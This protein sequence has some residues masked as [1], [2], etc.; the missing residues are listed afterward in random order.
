MSRGINRERQVKKRLE[1]DGWWVCRA[2][3]SLG[4]ADLVAGR[5]DKRPMLLEIKSDKAEY[6]PFNNFG[7][8]DREELL[9]AAE[10]T[11]WDA[12]LVYW[13][14]YGEWKWISPASWP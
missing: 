3:G 9:A 11:G 1:E 5:R 2:A 14:P 7:P 13:P 12:W 8:K 10:K 4:D 6:G